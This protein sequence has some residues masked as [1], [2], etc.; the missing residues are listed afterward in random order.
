MWSIC[1]FGI[2]EGINWN[3]L[4]HYRNICENAVR[5]IE[6]NEMEGIDNEA[7]NNELCER[8]FRMANEKITHC[9]SVKKLEKVMIKYFNEK[10]ARLNQ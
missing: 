9:K 2:R 8:V 6:R 10:S 1:W 4:K 7:P 3:L 5:T